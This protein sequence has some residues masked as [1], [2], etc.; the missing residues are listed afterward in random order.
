MRRT[1][2]FVLVS[3]LEGL[4][5]A[6]LEATGRGAPVVLSD[7][8]CHREVVGTAGPGA[9][10]VPVDDVDAIAR[11]IEDTL[12]DP[13]AASDARRRRERVLATYDWDVVAASTEAF[14]RRLR[15]R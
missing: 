10:L 7:L 6:L 13:A 1:V 12:N 4:P 8:P 14:Y 3:E 15:D 11:A 2:V 9:R 5:I